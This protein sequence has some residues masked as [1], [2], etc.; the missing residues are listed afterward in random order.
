M[1]DEHDMRP[2]GQ[3][4]GKPEV[5]TRILIINSPHNLV[6]VTSFSSWFIDRRDPHRHPR[7]LT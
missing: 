6:W 4:I 2:V 1:L 5:S 3:F 7:Q